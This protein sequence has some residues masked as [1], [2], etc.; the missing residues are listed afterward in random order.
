M[1]QALCEVLGIEVSKVDLEPAPEAY[2]A[3]D[4]VNLDK[5]L[6]LVNAW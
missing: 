6:I 1:C 2:V 5:A 4:V 3:A